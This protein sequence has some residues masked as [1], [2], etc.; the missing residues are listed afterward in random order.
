[1]GDIQWCNQDFLRPASRNTHFSASTVTPGGEGVSLQ[2][3]GSPKKIAKGKSGM[4]A[5]CLKMNTGK[6]KVM[7]GCNRTN[8]L[9]ESGKWPLQLSKKR[10]GDR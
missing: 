3:V 6:T 8:K 1:M 9:E 10:I 4:L 5:K 7:L 2:C